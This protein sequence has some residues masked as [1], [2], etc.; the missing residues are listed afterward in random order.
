VVISA[1][2]EPD[3]WTSL[4]AGDVSGTGELVERYG[5]LVAAGEALVLGQLGQSLDGFIA[6][7]TG[8]ARFVTGAADREHL[9]RLRALVDAVVVGVN[10]VIADDPLL[11]VRDVTGSCPT[12]VILD[13]TGRAPLGARVFR[14]DSAPTLW[15]VGEGVPPL[16]LSLHH[17]DVVTLP[18]DARSGCG[19]LPQAVI[20]VLASRGLGRVLVEGGGVTVSRFLAAGAIDRLW[21]TTAPVLVGDGIPGL[22]FDGHDRLADA[23]RAPAR[24]F[25]LGDDMALEL[26]LAAHRRR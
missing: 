1:I 21:V 2:N 17:G 8:D 9:H 24:R 23:L 16:G 11:T 5:V 4:L 6:S 26:N 14:D 10:T 7:R 12:R 22:R 13:P 15:V 19:F 20:E 3:D 25:V 18:L